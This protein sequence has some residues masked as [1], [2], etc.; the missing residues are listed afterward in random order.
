MRRR[1]LAFLSP[2]RWRL[3]ALA[4]A[5]PLLAG[6]GGAPLYKNEALKV[7]GFQPPVGW[8][9]QPGSTYPRLLAAWES[10]DGGRLT[11]V[12]QRVAADTTARSLLDESR[13]AL[14]RQGFRGVT[15]TTPHPAGDDSDRAELDAELD[16][17]RRFVRQLY[18]VSG[19]VGY[20]LTMV[21][22][23]VREIQMKR[24]FDEAA[25]SLSVGDVVAG[26]EVSPRR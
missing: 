26:P 18:V 21:G 17:G 22:P 6:F 7:R 2:R 1:P 16:E 20:V 11:L 5:L 12:A 14:E 19:G 15:V 25:A 13:P 3:V 9:L 4:L 8:E 23:L 10:R 24:D